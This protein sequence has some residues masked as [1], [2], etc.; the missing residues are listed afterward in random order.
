MCVYALQ[1]RGE[2]AV[3]AIKHEVPDAKL[4]VLECE[5]GSLRSVKACAEAF[6]ATGKPL[7]ILMLNAGIMATPF[8]LS[9]GEQQTQASWVC[10]CRRCMSLP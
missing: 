4:T 10:A 8:A 3:A 5:L 6:K 9:E 1:S 7:H 2:A